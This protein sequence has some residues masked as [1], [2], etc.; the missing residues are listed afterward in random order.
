MFEYE[1][2]KAIKEEIK[3]KNISIDICG[4]H[5]DSVIYNPDIIPIGEK[6]D[7]LFKVKYIENGKRIGT[8]ITYQE[9]IDCKAIIK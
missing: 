9:S 6:Y 5:I 4:N 8:W 2:A 1:K 7:I 3:D